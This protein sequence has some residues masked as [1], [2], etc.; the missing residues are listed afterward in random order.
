MKIV[1]LVP[2]QCESISR[3]LDRGRHHLFQHQLAEF[4]LSGDHPGH[5]AGHADRLIAIFAGSFD[6]VAL[7]IEV[8]VTGRGG[9][10]LFTIIDK[11]RLAVGHTDQHESAAPDI[12]R[13]R[14]YDGEG[15]PGSYGSV[16]SIPARL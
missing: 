9:G 7:S 13:R 5:R 15:K 14:M 1:S 10:S 3:E 2:S 11:V 8:H 4:F 6:H 12:A 16:D